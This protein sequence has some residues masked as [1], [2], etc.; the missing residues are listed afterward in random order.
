MLVKDWFLI[1]WKMEQIILQTK[2]MRSLKNN[3]FLQ[4]DHQS[5]LSG[6][7][8]I[9]PQ[10]FENGRS[11]KLMSEWCLLSPHHTNDYDGVYYV[12]IIPTL[13][14]PRCLLWWSLCIKLQIFAYTL[15]V[16]LKLWMPSKD[17]DCFPKKK[18]SKRWC[19][20]WPPKNAK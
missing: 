5:M 12:P 14:P 6:T 17:N 3:L 2:K 15:Y 7:L 1:V 20:E 4:S 9:Y 8:L 10:S 18:N 19:T 13:N 11:S 16:V